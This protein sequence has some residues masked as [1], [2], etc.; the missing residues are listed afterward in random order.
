VPLAAALLPV[1]DPRAMSM[2]GFKAASSFVVLAEG[3]EAAAVSSVSVD[4]AGSATAKP[5]ESTIV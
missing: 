4:E 5:S 2:E 3:S 1:H